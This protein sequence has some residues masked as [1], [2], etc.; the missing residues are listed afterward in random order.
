MNAVSKLIYTLGGYDYRVIEKINPVT[1]H[2]AL[3]Y[4]VPGFSLLIVLLTAG[5]G[6]WHFTSTLL[7]TSAP[8][9]NLYHILATSVFA[10]FIFTVDYLILNSGKNLLILIARVILSLGLGSVIA[11]LTTLS[12]FT[13]DIAAENQSQKN[14]LLNPIDSLCDAQISNIKGEITGYEKRID[15]LRDSA[16][17]ERQGRTKS[18]V[19]GPGGIWEEIHGNII[20][21]STRLEERTANLRLEE[22]EIEDK[23]KRD[24][25]KVEREFSSNNFISQ[26]RSLWRLMKEN[27][28]SFYTIIFILSV[29]ICDLIP[30]LAKIGKDYSKEFDPYMEYITSLKERIKIVDKDIPIDFTDIDYLRKKNDKEL[31]Q[32]HED[33][34]MQINSLY[35]LEKYNELLTHFKNKGIPEEVVKKIFNDFQ[36][37]INK[38]K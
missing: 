32:F 22:Q 2:F 33:A 25:E 8:N 4:F 9:Y 30:L 10:F 17:A 24:K 15:A 29:L 28:V 31:W 21:D 34:L 11:I 7:N 23:R 27:I 14:Q 36:E 18:G 6:G 20:R 19:P 5:Y 12:F 35:A 38:R 16:I 13:D 3:R 26:V 37:R 1:T